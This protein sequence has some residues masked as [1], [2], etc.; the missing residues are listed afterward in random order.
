VEITKRER[1]IRIPLTES[2]FKQRFSIA[3]ELAHLFF[4]AEDAAGIRPA[5]LDDHGNSDLGTEHRT[6]ERLETL[7]DAI[8]RQILVPTAKLAEQASGRFSVNLELLFQ[9]AKEFEVPPDVVFVRLVETK[10]VPRYPGCILLHFG[11]NRFTGRDDKWRVAARVMPR[12]I[13]PDLFWPNRGTGLEIIGISI[14][15]PHQLE[16]T[17]APL[18][19]N[20][21]VQSQHWQLTVQTCRSEPHWALGCATLIAD[22][23]AF[24]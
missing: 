10:L 20:F 4:I 16:T 3:H 23:E 19:Y 17:A 7:C 1:V 12:S 24:L 13:P 2:V 14:P 22:G 15:A 18:S 21:K 5:F 6:K 11:P 8:A 9:F